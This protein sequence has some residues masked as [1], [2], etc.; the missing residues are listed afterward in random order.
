MKYIDIHAH[1]NFQD[2]D[3][4]RDQIISDLQKNEIGVIN[5]GTGL[6]TSREII[7]LSDTHEN[8]W[9]IIGLHPIYV[10]P[11]ERGDSLHG[12]ED[13]NRLEFE[14]LLDNKKVVGIGECGLDYFHIDSTN[15]DF[16]QRQKENFLKQIELSL[17][18]DLPIMI[19]CRQAYDDVL[20]I[21]KHYKK[22]NSRLRGNMHF[23]SGNKEHMKDL[24]D[25]DFTI[26]FTGV[27]TF[28]KEYIDLVEYVPLEKMH[29]ETDSPY[30]SPAPN[31]GQRN[32]P[33]NVIY[34]V[35]KIAEIKKLDMIDV[36]ESLIKNAKRDFNLS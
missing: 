35:E 12:G 28:A 8:M 31:R 19:H 7:K 9:S 1:L 13:F 4:D 11:L 24:L 25:L 33:N 18:K 30:V 32:N 15:N 21:L 14:K 26:S 29:A 6:E 34:V 36:S 2:F 23:F 5:I 27:V 22:Q 16:K 20:D 10:N 17:E 3:M